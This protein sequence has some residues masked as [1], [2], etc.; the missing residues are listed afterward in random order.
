MITSNLVK[1][2]FFGED[3]NWG[4]I[5]CAMGYSG[6]QFDPLQVSLSLNS[7]AG[8]ILLLEDGT[9]LAFDEQQAL[10]VLKEH[11]IQVI[12]EM[13]TQGSGSAVAWGC[14]L[15]YEYVRINGEYRS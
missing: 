4:R 3:A 1:T 9:P 13:N 10:Q 11:E 14:D 7:S 15:S 5:L 6:V 2:A 8:T 12:I